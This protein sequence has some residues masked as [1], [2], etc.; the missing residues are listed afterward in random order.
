VL[1]ILTWK[2][3]GH[4]HDCAFTSLFQSACKSANS[5]E[6]SLGQIQ[7]LGRENG[8]SPIASSCGPYLGWVFPGLPKTVL[9]YTC[10][11]GIIINNYIHSQKCLC[12]DDKSYCHLSYTSLIKP[13]VDDLIFSFFLQ[14]KKTFPNTNTMER[15]SAIKQWWEIP[16]VPRF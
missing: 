14:C 15:L 9:V 11:S 7:Q 3:I 10:S 8:I 4:L 13:G 16:D 6:Q 12:L 1:V 2:C 5:Q